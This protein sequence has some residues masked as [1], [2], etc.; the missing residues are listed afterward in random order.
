M[1]GNS[2]YGKQRQPAGLSEAMSVGS[3]GGLGGG[4]FPVADSAGSE[5]VCSGRGSVWAGM[6]P[7]QSAYEGGA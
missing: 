4:P 5:C 7:S 6:L 1:P 3:Q 2:C